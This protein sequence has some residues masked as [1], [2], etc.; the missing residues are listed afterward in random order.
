MDDFDA[1]LNDLESPQEP[2]IGELNAAV[3]A[4]RKSKG[5]KNFNLADSLQEQLGTSIDVRA[6]SP[7]D[8]QV[9]A[10]RNLVIG[11]M[12]GDVQASRA[13]MTFTED[14]SHAENDDLFDM[15]AGQLAA[16]AEQIAREF[17]QLEIKEAT[18]Q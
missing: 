15:T 1:I 17:R 16:E 2:P 5:A 3:A 9:I 4:K 8:L 10:V 18:S 14:V 7:E 11:S 12:D 6:V 13:L